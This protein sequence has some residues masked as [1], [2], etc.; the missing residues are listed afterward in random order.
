MRLI[1]ARI[2]FNFDME[3]V[4]VTENRD[5][6][7]KQ[8]IYNFWEKGLLYVYLTPVKKATSD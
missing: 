7:K 1:L 2:V 4:D 8:L 6:M 3:L 5:W